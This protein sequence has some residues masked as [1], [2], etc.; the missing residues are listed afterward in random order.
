MRKGSKIMDYPA[1]D[2]EV[3]NAFRCMGVIGPQN[4]FAGVVAI[5]RG[6]LPATK[7]FRITEEYTDSNK[8]YVYIY[9]DNELQLGDDGFVKANQVIDGSLRDQIEISIPANTMVI[10]SSKEL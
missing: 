1:N 10:L 9:N 2:P 3:D 8:I 6:M 5:N 4:A 7:T